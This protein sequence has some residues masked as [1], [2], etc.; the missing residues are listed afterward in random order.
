MPGA[1]GCEYPTAGKRPPTH[2]VP[3]GDRAAISDRGNQERPPVR[4]STAQRP[5]RVCGTASR[6][7]GGAVFGEDGGGQG[8]VVAGDSQGGRGAGRFPFLDH[9]R[10]CTVGILLRQRTDLCYAEESAFSR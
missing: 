1:G 6:G 9:S 3:D 5:A 4:Q 10:Y 7:T 2:R 8:R